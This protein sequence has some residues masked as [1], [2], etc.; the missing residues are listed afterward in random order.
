MGMPVHRPGMPNVVAAMEISNIKGSS[1]K[2]LRDL[3]YTTASE[4]RVRLPGE[5]ALLAV[6]IC[7]SEISDV[8]SV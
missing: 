6:H 2:E 4:I 8:L 1:V 5:A 3:V 7:C